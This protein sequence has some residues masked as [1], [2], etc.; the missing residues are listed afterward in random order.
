MNRS[1]PSRPDHRSA[2]VGLGGIL[3]RFDDKNECRTLRVMESTETRKSHRQQT[4]LPSIAELAATRRPVNEARL[5]PPRVFHDPEV[6]EF[7]R[8]W[9]ARTWLCVGREADFGAPGTYALV[10]VTGE[11]L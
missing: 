5:L 8:D 7:E 1:T 6:F 9:F 11:G 10:D 3:V 2:T 4:G